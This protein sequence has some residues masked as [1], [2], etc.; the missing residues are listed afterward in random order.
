MPVQLQDVS[1]LMEGHG[2]HL[3]HGSRTHSYNRLQLRH[4]NF[5]RRK[6]EKRTQFCET[7]TQLGGSENQ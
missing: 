1:P 2:S 6:S 4:A 5:Q 7:A 3:G